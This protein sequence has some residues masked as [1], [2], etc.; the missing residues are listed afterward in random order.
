MNH[1]SC[2]QTC[3][4]HVEQQQQVVR[5]DSF[6]PTGTW[7]EHPGEG[8]SSGTSSFFPS[9]RLHLLRVR[10]L[11]FILRSLCSSSFTSVSLWHFPNRKQWLQEKFESFQCLSES[12]L[13][14]MWNNLFFCVCVCVLFKVCMFVLRAGF[15]HIHRTS[16]VT[17]PV[18]NG[19]VISNQYSHLKFSVKT[20]ALHDDHET[21]MRCSSHPPIPP[22]PSSHLVVSCPLSRPNGCWQ[23]R[24]RHN[25]A[26]T[27]RQRLTAAAHHHIWE[28]D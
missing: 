1:I 28:S 16:V 9:W 21:H 27:W 8:R 13:S 25:T 4:S 12:N 20:R 5:S 14:H 10:L 11:F 24:R 26:Q 19:S 7:G 18:N 22:P 6:T 15:V 3:P 17:L 23:R 2:F